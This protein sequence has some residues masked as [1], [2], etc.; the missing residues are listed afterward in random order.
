MTIVGFLIQYQFMLHEAV[1][2]LP[3]Q[4]I[5]VSLASKDLFSLPQAEP[6]LVPA[7][8]LEIE[9]KLPQDSEPIWQTKAEFLYK[10]GTVSTYIIRE[11]K[12]GEVGVTKF[13]RFNIYDPIPE[14]YYPSIELY[15]TA[16]QEFMNGGEPEKTIQVNSNFEWRDRE[17]L[18]EDVVI[19]DSEEKAA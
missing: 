10:K 6:D 15:E 4:Q 13:G 18:A 9:S 1:T 5:D 12:P 17:P 7:P 2:K 8:L 16:R 11:H 3:I 14:H 19:F